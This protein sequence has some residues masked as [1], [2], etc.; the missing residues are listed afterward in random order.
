MN[1]VHRNPHNWKTYGEIVP[2]MHPTSCPHNSAMAIGHN[3]ISAV[4]AAGLVLF[5]HQRTSWS[6]GCRYCFCTKLV[7]SHTT[8]CNRIECSWVIITTPGWMLMAW[9]YFAPCHYGD[10]I[11][12]TIA[13]QIT[14]LTVVYSTVYSGADQKNIKA[15]RHWPLCGEFTGT[16]EFPAQR[17][18]N[19]EK[20]SIW[21]LYHVISDGHDEAVIMATT[22]YYIGHGNIWQYLY[23]IALNWKQGTSEGFDGCSRPSDFVNG[24]YDLE[25]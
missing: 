14:S 21:W 10:V 4:V 16:G 17:A 5:C 23:K 12:G 7:L 20:G 2:C 19:A 8:K 6:T 24:L 22:T 18:N 11:M 13:S 1:T 9:L 25:P 3:H 15:L